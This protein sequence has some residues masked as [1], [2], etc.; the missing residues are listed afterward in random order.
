[1]C[2]KELCLCFRSD[3][4]VDGLDLHRTEVSRRQHF[5]PRQNGIAVGARSS[6]KFSANGVSTSP[7]KYDGTSHEDKDAGST[8]KSEAAWVITDPDLKSSDALKALTKA[9]ESN[10]RAKNPPKTITTKAAGYD[11]DDGG[12]RRRASVQRELPGLQVKAS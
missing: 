9:M 7:P 5:E 2:W 10:E 6:P 12:L 11:G 8:P 1:M 4:D 3:T